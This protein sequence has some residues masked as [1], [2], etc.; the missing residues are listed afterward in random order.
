MKKNLCDDKNIFPISL[1]L[2][3][4]GYEDVVM[5]DKQELSDIYLSINN[6]SNVQDMTNYI[7]SQKGTNKINEELE[8]AT[9][10]FFP[11]SGL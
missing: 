1:F 10:N 2:S 4:L 5:L 3:Y 11:K 7:E 8:N 6:I 9:L